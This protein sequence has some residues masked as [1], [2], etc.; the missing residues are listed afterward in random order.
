ML[1]YSRAVIPGRRDHG[2]DELGE[3]RVRIDRGLVSPVVRCLRILRQAPER[4][5][6][7]GCDLLL[8]EIV[9]ALHRPNE[10]RADLQEQ[11]DVVSAR[12]ERRETVDDL[13]LQTVQP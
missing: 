8:S 9:A 1:R 11:R 13:L 3:M 5:D 7:P 12:K 2:N 10:T 6:S 4:V